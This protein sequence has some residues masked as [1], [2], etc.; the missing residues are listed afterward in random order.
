MHQGPDFAIETPPGG[1]AWWYLDA[2]SD[3]GRYGLTLIAFVGSVFSPYYYRARRLAKDRQALADADQ[4]VAINVALYGPGHR[5]RWAMTERSARVLDRTRDSYVL[6]PSSLHWD[7]TRLNGELRERAA[8]FGQAVAGRFQL[9]TEALGPPARTLCCSGAHQW[10]PIAPQARLE[11]TMTAPKLRW[12]GPAYFDHNRGA[13][14]LD[15]AFDYW[16]WSRRHQ[17]EGTEVY[18]ECWQRD[19]ERTLIA[20][21]FDRDGT[22]QPIAPEL[23]ETLPDTGWRIRRD[24]R[25]PGAKVAKTFEDTPFYARNLLRDGNGQPAVSENLDLARFRAP[26]V[27][28]LLP[29]RMPR[30][31]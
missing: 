14:P 24:A 3:D 1:Y 17:D 21:R 29:F 8:P 2:T 28:C 4:H 20:T 25:I 30:R 18:Y 9:N 22:P 10:G 31:A 12:S 27:Q 7:G 13:A 15:Q 16:T 26:W 6:G 11:L 23:R 5:K 19:G